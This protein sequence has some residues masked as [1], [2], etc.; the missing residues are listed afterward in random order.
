MVAT[1]AQGAACGT[2]MIALL[3][4]AIRNVARHRGRSVTAL[5]AIALGVAA[6]I[7]AGGFIHDVY[8]QF[9]EAIIH[10]QYGHLQI[11][12]TGY[13]AHGTQHPS[14]YVI[15]EPDPVERLVRQEGGVVLVTARLRFIGTA[16]T[17]GADL[18]IVG[19]GVEPEFENRLGSFI[20]IV[21]GRRLREDDR[22]GV[23]L[24]HGLA[25]ALHA[26]PGERLSINI[27]TRDGALNSLDFAILGV[28]R[29]HSEDFDSRGIRLPLASA[30]DLLATRGVNEIVVELA[31]TSSTQRIGA[32]LSA[33][34]G[35]Q[36]FEV[37]TWQ[38]LADFYTKTTQLFDRQFGFLQVVLLLMITLSV[39]NT[40]TTATF[41]RLPEFGTMLAIGD[42]R[43]EVF[44]LIVLESFVLGLVGAAIGVALGTILAGVIS[45]VGI[46]M[47]PPPNME[48]GYIAR[49][50]VV[51]AVLAGACAVGVLSTV[52]A[53][54]LPSVRIARM[55]PVDALRHAL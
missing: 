42:R 7:V 6:I 44:T 46:P 29:S 13:S 1:R 24:G 48:L 34:L 38:E 15:E 12:R 39:A 4:L 53:A 14:D 54:L 21:D 31:R 37:R 43:R 26:R 35:R 17:G 2:P 5:A 16:N 55:P 27:V 47:P 51:P 40:I 23:V 41:E 36:G 18:P 19:E 25:E 32:S 11:Y 8:D 10:S 49:V 20:Q 45:A 9:G 22:D 50:R 3:R 28:F 30:Q 52:L 33:T